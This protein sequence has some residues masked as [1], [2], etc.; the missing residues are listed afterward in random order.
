MIFSSVSPHMSHHLRLTYLILSA[1]LI[2]SAIIYPLL[3]AQIASQGD[4]NNHAT[5]QMP[6]AF[7]VFLLPAIMVLVA[8]FGPRLKNFDGYWLSIIAFLAYVHVLTLVWNMGARFNFMTLLVPAFAA[9]MY[10]LGALLQ[11]TPQNFYVG[12]RTPWTLKDA[13]VWRRTHEVGGRMYKIAAAVS[14][15]GLLAGNPQITVALLIAPIA[16]A[17]FG[18]MIYSYKISK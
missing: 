17:S 11:T 18:A 16:I 15:A 13:D 6:K 7:G 4:I 3:P 1:T 10:A 2:A 8:A 14:L 9:F 5:G 12:I